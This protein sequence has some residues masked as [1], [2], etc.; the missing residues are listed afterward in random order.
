[1]FITGRVRPSD[2]GLVASPKGAPHPTQAQVPAL[3]DSAFR[4][5]TLH[6]ARALEALEADWN[7]LAS[8]SPPMQQYIWSRTAAEV[9]V[10]R[11]A[12]QVV[13]LEREGRVRAIAPLV[14]CRRPLPRLEILGA[15]RLGEPTDLI[16]E[17][18]D[19][20]YVLVRAL[21]ALGKPLYLERIDAEAESVE[22]TRDVYQGGI[23]LAREG[24]GCSRI[25]LDES[26]CEPEAKFSPGWRAGLRRRQRRAARLGLVQYET[27][28]PSASELPALLDE[29][30]RIE[31]AGWK[32][33]AGS[34]LACD[35]HLGAF[36]RE[37]ARAACNQG[38]LRLLFMRIGGRAVSMQ[39]IV[40]CANAW[41][42]L[43]IGYDERF[44]RCSP[45]RLLSVHAVREAAARR[46]KSYE[47]L[48][49]TE[50]WTSEWAPQSRDLISLRAYP[51]GVLA[52]AQLGCE[53]AR[54]G[55]KKLVT[56]GSRS[57]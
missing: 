30:Y 7:A 32:G 31:A 10:G 15:D 44:A 47:F 42:Q 6:S 29:A 5:Q 8:N 13:A 26:W 51:R 40:E 56:L 36:F 4:L 53:V 20:R 49:V 35:P 14:L 25:A 12:T 39:M 2:D 22:V 3:P 48:G 34:A 24:P 1:M 37:Y 16:A 50:P 9:F 28:S 17:N 54:W 52:Y 19:V 43:K 27:L 33:K 46:L 45:G 11:G 23:V 55:G 57:G 21:L 18:R 38:I 41:W